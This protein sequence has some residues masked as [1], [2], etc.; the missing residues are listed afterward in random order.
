M[1]GGEGC[2]RSHS[3]RDAP[4]SGR[5]PP[6][7][8]VERDHAVGRYMLLRRAAAAFRRTKPSGRIEARSLRRTV[9]VMCFHRRIR[10][11]S[12]CLAAER[13]CLGRGLL[14]RTEKRIEVSQGVRGMGKTGIVGMG[15]VRLTEAVLHREGEGEGKISRK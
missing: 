5:S 11:R 2:L 10:R 12:I 1:W 14:Q 13:E 3:S 15:I 8:D 7:Y 6:P 4:G 9:P